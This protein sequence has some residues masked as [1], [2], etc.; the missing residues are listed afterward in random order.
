[1]ISKRITMCFILGLASNVVSATDRLTVE[2]LQNGRAYG[3]APEDMAEK[4]RAKTRSMSPIFLSV[5]VIKRYQQFGCARLDYRVRQEKVIGKD[6][7]LHP[8]QM[9]WQMNICLDGQPPAQPMIEVK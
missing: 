8:L 3:S 1:M 6:G 7:Q 9:E 2:A 4:I 5:A